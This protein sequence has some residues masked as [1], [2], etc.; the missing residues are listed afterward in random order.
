MNRP[1]M[2]SFSAQPKPDDNDPHG[3]ALSPGGALVLAVVIVAL[4]CF[5][6]SVFPMGF[7]HG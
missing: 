4:A 3:E 6:S 5:V 7:A 1:W 2:R